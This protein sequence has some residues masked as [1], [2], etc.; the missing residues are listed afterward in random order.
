MSM[1]AARTAAALAAAIVLSATVAGCGSGSGSGGGGIVIG[2]GQDAYPTVTADD[3]VT[4][5]DHVFV[6]TPSGITETEPRKADA[7]ADEGTIGRE[8]TLEVE[9]VL[10][11]AKSPAQAAPEQLDVTTVGWEFTD[12]DTDNRREIAIGDQ[13]R[14]ETGH[15]YIVAMK[16]TPAWCEP[17]DDDYTPA[18]WSGL[19]SDSLIPYDDGVIGKG[20]LEGTVRSV[21]ETRDAQPAADDPDVSLEDELTGR[22]ADELK[23][24]L[25]TAT[26]VPAA[27]RIVHPTD[28]GD[29]G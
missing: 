1:S 5:A 16:W 11:S 7:G 2:E 10:W 21:A 6:V 14:L 12:G 15:T 27:K 22:S 20:E 17:G 19:G 29:C 18:N 8:I 13:P 3:W 26:P 4:Y 24:R 9:D 28:E 23:A 25:A